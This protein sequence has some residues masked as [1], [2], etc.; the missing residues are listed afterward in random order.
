MQECLDLRW[1][2][3]SWAPPP[4]LTIDQWAEQTVVLPRA[5]AS[6]PG[7]INLDRTPYL[8][9]ILQA[10]TDPDVEEITMKTSTQVGKTTCELL[11]LLFHMDQDPWPCLYVGPKEDSVDSFNTDVIQRI[12]HES[13]GLWRHLTGSVHDMTRQAIRL[14]GA[15][16]HFASANSPADLAQRAICIL[17]LDECDKYPPFSGKEADPIALARERTRT[18]LFRKILKVSTP[19]TSYGYIHQEFMAGDR[20]RYW[21]PC[22]H[23]GAYQLLVMGSRDV[24]TPGIHWPPGTMDPERLIDE[25]SAWY[26]CAGCHQHISDEAKPAMLRKGRWVPEAQHILPDGSLE[27]TAPSRRRLSYHLSALYSPWL[28]W[29]RIAAEFLRSKD[30]PKDLMN[31][32]NSWEAEIWEETVAPTVAEHVRARESDYQ[33]GTIPRAARVMTAGID[34]QLDHAWY[35]LRAWGAYGESWLIRAGRVEDFTALTRV[36]FES[37][38]FLVGTQ[39]TL[40][41]ERVLMDSGYRT[42]EVYEYCRRTGCQA[43]KGEGRYERAFT[44]SHPQRAD[45]TVVPLVL[46]NT[47]YYKDKL[48]RLIHTKDGDP[49]AWHLPQG[50]DEEYYRHMVSE[51]KIRVHNKRTGQV[52]YQWKVLVSGAPNH[53]FDAEVLTLVAAETVDVEHRFVLPAESAQVQAVT[54]PQVAIRQPIVPPKLRKRP[55]FEHFRSRTFS[56]SLEIHETSFQSHGNTFYSRGNPAESRGNTYK[57]RG[58]TASKAWRAVQMVPYRRTA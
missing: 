6:E 19:T 27:G 55:K 8:R 10:V 31:F 35:A 49:G 20:R 54:A 4:R 48:R 34:V 30:S 50:L 5:V 44:V 52:D 25:R 14:N 9:E 7:P 42:D 51:Q 1:R 24:G 17:V 15:S 12:I 29:S 39:E 57:N 11:P 58:R 3:S 18:F 37:V 56:R 33:I 41:I 38:Y 23:C 16:I 53:L 28:T 13:P 46:V 36:L 43:S 47:G 32:R 45:G 26:E 40:L 22:P 2:T 21:V